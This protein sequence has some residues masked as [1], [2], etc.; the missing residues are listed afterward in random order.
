MKAALLELFNYIQMGRYSTGVWTTND[1]KTISISFLKKYGYLEP[2]IIKKGVLSYSINGNPNGAISIST[3]TIDEPYLEIAY[4]LSSSKT[5][6][7]KNIKYRV[8]L[9]KAASNLGKGFRYY[10]L[11]PFSFK[12]C[13][14]LYMAYGSHYYKH[15]EAYK[16]RIY[17]PLQQES[18]MGQIFKYH[19]INKVLDKLYQ[20]KV[21]S[22]YKGVKTKLVQRIETLQKKSYYFSGKAE[23][24]LNSPAIYRGCKTKSISRF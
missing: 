24:L 3:N 8:L 19:A 20:K 14:I 9:V 4:I 22:H 1:C 11:C 18:K 17:Y 5:E 10:F 21:K 23:D 6:E 7:R 2:G 15:R 16:N 12:R 13:E